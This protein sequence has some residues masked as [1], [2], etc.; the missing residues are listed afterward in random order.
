M[1]LALTCQRFKTI[2]S[3][4]ICGIHV[5]NRHRFGTGKD[6]NVRSLVSLVG[7]NLTTL[8]IEDSKYVGPQ[9]VAALIR[10]CPNLAVLDLFHTPNVCQYE[11][12]DFIASCGA[13]LKSLFLRDG[14]YAG[15]DA[16]MAIGSHCRS[17][18]DLILQGPECEISPEALTWMLSKCAGTLEHLSLANTFGLELS[19]NAVLPPWNSSGDVAYPVLQSLHLVGLGW[20]SGQDAYIICGV[21]HHHAPKLDKLRISPKSRSRASKV[22]MTDEQIAD[23]RVSMYPNFLADVYE[24]QD[25]GMVM[26]YGFDDPARDTSDGDGSGGDIAIAEVVAA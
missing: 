22:Q 20:L 10:Y 12:A 19:V 5:T 9:T 18:R 4:S 2:L 6:G 17:L 3:Q 26:A 11:L 15:N 13:N 8:Q 24:D 14:V 16:L 25:R 21:L 7:A 1:S 23:V